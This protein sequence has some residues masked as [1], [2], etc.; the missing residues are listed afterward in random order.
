MKNGVSP[1]FVVVVVVVVASLATVAT[2]AQPL[3]TWNVD[4]A[5]ITVSGASSGALMATQLFVAHSATFKG[6]GSLAGGPWF[7]GVGSFLRTVMECLKTPNLVDVEELVDAALRFER[8]DDIDP[9]GNLANNYGYVFSGTIDSVVPSGYSVKWEEFFGHFINETHIASEYGITAEHTMPT[10]YYN[11]GNP[12]TVAKPPYISN[13]NYD[14]VHAMFRHMYFE[15]ELAPRGAYNYSNLLSFDQGDFGGV[16][17]DSKAFVYVPTACRQ[18]TTCKLHVALHGCNQ[19]WSNPEVGTQFV[20]FAG[21]NLWA[22]T[23]NIIVLYPQTEPTVLLGNPQGCWDWWGY[24]GREYVTRSGR[25][26]QVFF[27]ERKRKK[28]SLT[29]SCQA[30]YKMV[31]QLAGL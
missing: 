14:V 31:A 5:Q 22:E 1:L 7:C 15:S 28:Q 30:I 19:F 3:G 12:C 16:S 29:M 13:C 26:I 23:N 18:G 10:D 25:Q 4:P 24:T 21:Y 17:M 8:T 2:R 6:V 9:L 11:D 27:G 20:E